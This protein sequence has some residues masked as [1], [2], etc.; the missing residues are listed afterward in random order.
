MLRLRQ[1]V[2]SVNANATRAR[3]RQ[4]RPERSGGRR[5]SGLTSCTSWARASSMPIRS[6]SARAVVGAAPAPTGAAEG[7]TRG[8]STRGA[9]A[10]QAAVVA[11][12]GA[13]SPCGRGACSWGASAGAAA[14]GPRRSTRS[15]AW[16]ESSWQMGRRSSSVRPAMGG[17]LRGGERLARLAVGTNRPE[18]IAART[19]R[20]LRAG[21]KEYAVTAHPCGSGRG[22]AGRAGWPPGP[23]TMPSPGRWRSAAGGCPTG[24]A[25]VWP[26]QRRSSNR[27]ACRANVHVATRCCRRRGAPVLLAVSM[28]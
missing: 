3:R 12:G 19:K 10:V 22:T 24:Q 4:R 16:R 27:P 7:A 23:P 8:S 5:D 9:L 2:P 25:P 18:R 20:M 6:S 15:A 26:A 14:G 11:R 17:A 1:G 13:P 28:K 21:G